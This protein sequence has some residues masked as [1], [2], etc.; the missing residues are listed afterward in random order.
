[1]Q[2]ATS[3][4]DG[5]TDGATSTAD[6][7]TD[8]ASEGATSTADAGDA[9][10]LY[11]G[12]TVS[13][14]GVMVS[15]PCTECRGIPSLTI[16][17]Y[18]EPL[19]PCV[20][21]TSSGNFDIYVPANSNTALTFVGNG[22][23]SALMAFSTGPGDQAGWEIGLSPAN[24]MTAL[25]GALGL[26]FPAASTGFV[27]T[28]I[29]VSPP[30]NPNTVIGLVGATTAISPQSGVGPLYQTPTLTP[31]PS[32]TS[33]TSSGAAFF[34]GVTPG[35]VT[36]AFT[37]ASGSLSCTPGVGG[38]VGAAPNEITVPVTAGF[39]SYAN[40][41]CVLTAADAGADASDGSTD[42]AED[43]GDASTD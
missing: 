2:D 30:G 27:T 7:D 14:E 25:A 19:L 39:D 3:G 26:P 8:G 17:V 5:A 29:A 20:T 21:T 12:P 37:T 32:A 16:C 36:V 9:G 43:A 34:G 22:Y 6:A 18:N 42:A 35:E 28:G 24:E 23:D 10:D 13:I 15:Y 11:P 38:W 4:T 1:M 41:Y 33:T 31:D 40:V